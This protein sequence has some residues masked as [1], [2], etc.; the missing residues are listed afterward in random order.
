[1]VVH[2]RVVATAGSWADTAV[3]V[4]PTLLGVLALAVVAGAVTRAAV[5][6]G[7]GEDLGVRRSY[8]FA[9]GRVWPLLAVLVLSWLLIAIGLVL[10]V[11]PGRS[12][13][14]PAGGRR[15]G[16]GGRGHRAGEGPG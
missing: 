7:G 13:R 12:R 15:P 16:A 9:A 3:V 5:A 2:H 1:V 11:V 8:R 10:L 14:R 6:A 4:L